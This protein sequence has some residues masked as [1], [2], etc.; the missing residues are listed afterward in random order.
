MYSL[1]ESVEIRDATYLVPIQRFMEAFANDSATI[2]YNFLYIENW[3]GIQFL[4]HDII[5]E[6]LER[7]CIAKLQ[8]QKLGSRLGKSVGGSGIPKNHPE[9]F[10]A[11]KRGGI[12]PNHVDKFAKVTCTIMFEGVKFWYMPTGDRGMIQR[13]HRGGEPVPGS[14]SLKLKL[15]AEM[16]L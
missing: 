2:P 7:K 16:V 11:T 3:T 4:P 8:H 6:S 14:G 13:D 1:P 15:R 12:S 5:E 9:F 10:V